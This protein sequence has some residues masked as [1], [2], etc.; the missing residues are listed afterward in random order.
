MK[1]RLQVHSRR[2]Y[3]GLIKKFK[4]RRMMKNML[5]LIYQIP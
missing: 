1:D 5:I 4:K 2:R 3:S